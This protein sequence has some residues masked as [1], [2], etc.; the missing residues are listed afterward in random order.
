MTKVTPVEHAADLFGEIVEDTGSRLITARKVMPATKAAMKPDPSSAFAMPYAKQEPAS[1]RDHLTPGTVDHVLAAGVDDHRSDQK[2]G[3]D[4]ADDAEADLIQEQASAPVRPPEILEVTSAAATAAKSS[5]TQIPSLR[6]L[7]TSRAWR[8][9][10]GTRGSVTTAWPRAA[11]VGARMIAMIAASPKVSWSKITPAAS[12][13]SAIVSGSPIPSRRTGTPTSRRSA[14]RSMREASEKSTRASVASA[15]ALAVELVLS[16]SIPSRTL[17]PTLNSIET[18]MIAGVIGEPDNRLETAA[19][20][21]SAK[22]KIV[23]DHSI[24]IGDLRR[25]LPRRR[26]TNG[27]KIGPCE[28]RR[29]LSQPSGLGLSLAMAVAKAPAELAEVKL[30]QPLA[31]RDTVAKTDLIAQ[32][33]ASASP[34]VTVVAP[35]G[36]GKTTLLATWAEDDSRSFAWLAID[37][38]DDEAIVLLRNIA[39]AVHRVEPLPAEVLDAL[40]GPGGSIW[41]K[42]VPRLGAALGALKRPLV[43]VL[44][45]LHAVANPASLD[46]LAELLEYVPAGSQIAVAEQRGAAPATRPL[47]GRGTDA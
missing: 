11:S 13:P 38:R 17:G 12:A 24:A 32:L 45:D 16:M 3:G 15:S 6:P 4:A 44:D 30:A 22:A 36:Y 19:T 39:G 5:G 23:S 21:I 1:R 42:R 9:R 25:A 40:S 2:R 20:A 47:A 37:D 28:R 35:A 26:H 31:R 41:A 18:N 14:P 34:L 43:L 46:T 33:S 7:S 10:P 8:I 27:M 29:R